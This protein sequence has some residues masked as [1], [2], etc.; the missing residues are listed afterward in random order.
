MQIQGLQFF[1]SQNNMLIK[2]DYL[3]EEY[4]CITKLHLNR[5]GDSVSC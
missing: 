3:K 4:I 1:C 5:D 2:N